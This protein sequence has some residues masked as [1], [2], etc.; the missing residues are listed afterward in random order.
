M[1]FDIMTGDRPY[2]FHY[3]SDGKA[4]LLAVRN[5]DIAKSG[6]TANILL[7]VGQYIDDS[8]RL[9]HFIF[10]DTTSLNGGYYDL[11]II[12]S[13]T[14]IDPGTEI[15]YCDS[16]INNSAFTNLNRQTEVQR[17]S[18][19]TV[20]KDCTFTDGINYSPEFIPTSGAKGD[21]G[22]FD[23]GT[24]E[25]TLKPNTDY[26]IRITNQGGISDGT[27]HTTCVWYESGE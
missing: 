13:P 9:V 19:V 3:I 17:D 21:T 22:V 8:P 6:G 15:V 16:A 11:D 25:R 10:R 24:F 5:S 2:W 23:A 4:Y 18:I 27:T 14:V 7:R 26:I 1:S 20:Y 12:E